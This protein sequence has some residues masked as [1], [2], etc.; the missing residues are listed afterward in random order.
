PRPDP[1]ATST[2]R[3]SFLYVS[4]EIGIGAA[5]VLDGDVFG[6][7]HGWSGELG[8]TAVDPYGALCGCGARGCLETLAGK[9]ALYRAAG[10]A[11]DVPAADL[12][13]LAAQDE[14]V[15]GAVRAA[16]E[17]LGTGLANFVNLVDVH[18]VV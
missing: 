4:G 13:A 14:G 15:A 9:A 2:G 17:A 7:E 8:H 1:H 10:I 16:G 18:D 11:P 6:G 5:V 3:P 12:V